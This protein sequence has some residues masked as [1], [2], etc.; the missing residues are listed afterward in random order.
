MKA[1]LDGRDHCLADY[2]L[3]SPVAMNGSAKLRD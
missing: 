3:V 1:V 2:S